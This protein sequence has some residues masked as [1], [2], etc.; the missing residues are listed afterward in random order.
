MENEN[1]DRI[2]RISG[3]F[4]CLFT[5]LIISIP[6]LTLLFWLF[7]NDLSKE[8]INNNFLFVFTRP[9]P[10]ST[11]FLAFIVSL[12]PAS[13]AIYGIFTLRKLFTLYE[14]GV[15][16][17]ATN[18]V[19]IRKLGYSL[20]AWVIAN[21]VYLP[22]I[23]VVLTRNNLPGE[24]SISA[25]ISISDLATLIIGAIVLIISWVMSEASKLEDEQTHTV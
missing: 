1:L 12:I 3:K 15:V 8:F 19:C 23:S 17:A 2:K 20:I 16:F 25:G 18:V 14:Q 13:V 11:L 21:L 6:I 24:R 7:F 5:V 9:L 22:L 4:R 10:L